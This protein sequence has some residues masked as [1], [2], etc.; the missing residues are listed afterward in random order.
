MQYTL[1]VFNQTVVI[2]TGQ[3]PRPP[4]RVNTVGNLSWGR[5][6]NSSGSPAVTGHTEFLGLML[7]LLPALTDV[8]GPLS[9]TG[10][11]TIFPTGLRDRRYAVVFVDDFNKGTPTEFRGALCVQTSVTTPLD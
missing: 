11:D 3:G 4:T 1:P 5:R 9:T 6:Q 10:S 2:A 7:V 8:R